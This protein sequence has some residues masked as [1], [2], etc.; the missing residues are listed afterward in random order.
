MLEYVEAHA[1]SF[2]EAANKEYLDLMPDGG[3]DPLVY[4][5][6]FRAELWRNVLVRVHRY[7]GRGFKNA[8]VVRFNTSTPADLP[9]PPKISLVDSLQ[10][11]VLQHPEVAHD[12]KLNTLE[13]IETLRVAV[14]EAVRSW[15]VERHGQAISG[16][17]ANRGM[18]AEA[19]A[20]T[21]FAQRRS[22][23]FPWASQTGPTDRPNSD[24]ARKLF[25]TE[26]RTSFTDQQRNAFPWNRTNLSRRE[27][28]SSGKPADAAR[29]ST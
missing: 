20:R 12:R 27:A 25:P 18:L 11:V 22:S 1:A 9:G 28:S 2:T 26:E 29:V 21:D 13:A 16:S 3:M 24:L 10:H 7:V 17:E 14:K 23:S 5:E 15:K 8:C 6:R 19:V 4:C